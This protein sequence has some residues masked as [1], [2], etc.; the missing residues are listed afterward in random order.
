LTPV[1]ELVVAGRSAQ[2][3]DNALLRDPK[4]WVR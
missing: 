2:L 3:G 4:H 1:V